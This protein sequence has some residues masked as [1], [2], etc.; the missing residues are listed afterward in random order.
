[1]SANLVHALASDCHDV[2][3]RPPGFK[4]AVEQASAVLPGIEDQLDWYCRDAPNALL[5]GRDLP[6]RPESLERVRQKRR[7]PL[8]GR[9][10][11]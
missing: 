4:A 7:L 9:K 1:M 8:L 11:T 10:R 3:R 6:P 2:V 5:T